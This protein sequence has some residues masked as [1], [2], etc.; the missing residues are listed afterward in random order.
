MFKVWGKRDIDFLLNM[1]NLPDES[2]SNYSTIQ[3]I[4]YFQ[5]NSINFLCNLIC[6]AERMSCVSPWP[7]NF[8]SYLIPN[9]Y[10]PFVSSWFVHFDLWPFIKRIFIGL[11]TLTFNKENIT[12]FLWMTCKNIT[13]LICIIK[14]KYLKI[15]IKIISTKSILKFNV[16][17]NYFSV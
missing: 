14:I 12:G 17:Q 7:V 5:T 6:Y 4:F 11:Y 13:K 9:A 3:L 10:S 1:Y 2:A 15:Q 8:N 16:Y